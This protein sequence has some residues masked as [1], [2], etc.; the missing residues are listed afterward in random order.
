MSTLTFVEMAIDAILLF[1]IEKSTRRSPPRFGEIPIVD[2]LVRLHGSG[3]IYRL[4]EIL[5]QFYVVFV[6]QKI[7]LA[8]ELV[9]LPPVVEQTRGMALCE[10]LVSLTKTIAGRIKKFP[11]EAPQRFWIASENLAKQE[12]HSLLDDDGG[13]MIALRR[14]F[15]WAT[16]DPEHR[17][18]GPLCESVTFGDY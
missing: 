14:Q 18:S 12:F 17:K 16:D 6:R 8:R 2:R 5:Y 11:S 7:H 15:F 13:V 1:S 3:D 9:W 4:A 10:F